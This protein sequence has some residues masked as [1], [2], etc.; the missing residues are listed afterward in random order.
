MKKTEIPNYFWLARTEDDQL[1]V[2]TLLGLGPDYLIQDNILQRLS[3]NYPRGCSLWFLIP[4]FLLYFFLGIAEVIEENSFLAIMLLSFFFVPLVNFAFVAIRHRVKAKVSVKLSAWESLR[5]W[6]YYVS[7]GQRFVQVMWVFICVFHLSVGILFGRNPG[8]ITFY[9]VILC[10][11]LFL[12]VLGYIPVA[13][14]TKEKLQQMI[15]I[16]KK[17]AAR[18][19]EFRV[20]YEQRKNLNEKPVM[21]VKSLD[22]DIPETRDGMLF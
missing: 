18:V 22:D 11:W 14:K 20:Y 4:L 16:N 17:I 15:T 7:P 13:L 10:Y 9:L 2:P 1:A 3:K 5:V 19:P 12:L 21:G 8:P 6:A